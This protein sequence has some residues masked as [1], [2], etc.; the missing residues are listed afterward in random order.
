MRSLDMADTKDSLREV[1]LP[2]NLC[3]AAEKLLP[4]TPFATLEQL[5]AFV[6]EELTARDATPLDQQERRLIEQRLRDLGYL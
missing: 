3:E 6:L 5:L 1:R 2:S 4:Q